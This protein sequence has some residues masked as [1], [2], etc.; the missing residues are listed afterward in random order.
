VLY[1]RAPVLMVP[2]GC[3]RLAAA[4]N[5]VVAWNGSA[6]AA[7]A[8][9][10]ALPL[11]SEV[12]QVHVVEV[13]EADGGLSSGEAVTWLARKGVAAEQ[14][15]WPAKGRR[16][17][18]ALLHAAAELGAGLLVMGAYGHSRLRETVLGGVTRDLIGMTTLPLLMAH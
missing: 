17:S 7:Q 9:R 14:H 12:G 13:C 11:L 3:Q 18:V 10:L 1:C 15:E 4:T 16:V 5:A 2:A 6:E 8:L